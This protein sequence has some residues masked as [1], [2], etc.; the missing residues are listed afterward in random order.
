MIFRREEGMSKSAYKL[1]GGFF[2]MDVVR[3]DDKDHEEPF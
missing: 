1:R 2:T 3:P